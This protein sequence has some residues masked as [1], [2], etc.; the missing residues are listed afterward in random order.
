MCKRARLHVRVDEAGVEVDLGEALRQ[1]H[2]FLRRM[3]EDVGAGLRTSNALQGL[4]R[5][6]GVWGWWGVGG[7]RGGEGVVKGWCGG[8]ERL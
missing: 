2:G 7:E 5:G 4:V 6:G 1:S 8:G 3:A